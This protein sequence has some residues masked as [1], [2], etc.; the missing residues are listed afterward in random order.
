MRNA[1]SSLHS[2]LS[3][4]Q[5]QSGP[6]LEGRGTGSLWTLSLADRTTL[7]ILCMVWEEERRRDGR[8]RR[9]ETALSRLQRSQI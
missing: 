9:E 8:I 7:A 1:D 4:L 2:I 3:G 6:A 5:T